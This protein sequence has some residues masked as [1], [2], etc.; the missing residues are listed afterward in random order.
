MFAKEAK[1]PT[2]VLLT[3][4]ATG[5][6]PKDIFLWIKRDGRIVTKEDGLVSSGVR[7]NHDDTFQRR[8][9][10]EILRSDMSTYTCEVIHEA[11]KVNERRQWGKNI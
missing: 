4:L 1:V 6:Y 7:P 11:S 10:V 3:C 5:F 8:D 2:N 9:S